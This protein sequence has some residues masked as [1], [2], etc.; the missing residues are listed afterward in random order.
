VASIPEVGIPPRANCRSINVNK[1]L[2]LDAP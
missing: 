2:N 1:G